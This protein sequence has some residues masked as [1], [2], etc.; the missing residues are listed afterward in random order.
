MKKILLSVVVLFAAFA[1]K[2]AEPTYTSTA[3]VGPYPGWES[4]NYQTAYPT[5]ENATVEVYSDSIVVRNF[6]G[7]EGYDM[8]VELDANGSITGL[9]SIVNGK[10]D[11]YSS[12]AYWYLYTGLESPSQM[13]AYVGTNYSFAWSTDS[14]KSGGILLSTYAYYGGTTSNVWSYYYIGWGD[15]VPPTYITQGKV[16]SYSAWGTSI[17]PEVESVDVEVYGSDS[18]IVRDFCGVSGYDMCTTLDASGNVASIY[19]IVNDTANAYC[20]NSYWYVDT[21]LDS[22][23]MF[24]PYNTSGYTYAWS[25]D[26]T[27]SGGIILYGYVYTEPNA[28]SAYSWTHY[29]VGWGDDAPTLGINSVR[30]NTEAKETPIYNLAGQRVSASAKGLVIKNGKKYFVK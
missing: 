12:G 23:W 8:R 14:T 29:F 1:A 16:G 7:V 27:K 19:P 21:G 26:T 6:C 3:K 2:A 9:I 30:N 5:S 20:S 17:F 28:Y 22:M 11:P 24:S 25:N 15:Q 18:I 4:A 13:M 10:D